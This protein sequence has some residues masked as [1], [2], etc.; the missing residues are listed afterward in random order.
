MVVIL[1]LLEVGI[2]AVMCPNSDAGGRMQIDSS[3]DAK[4]ADRGIAEACSF[5]EGHR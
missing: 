3:Q 1:I 5:E 2:I 4:S